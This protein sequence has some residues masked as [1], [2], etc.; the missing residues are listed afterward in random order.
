MKLSEVIW[1][2][3]DLLVGFLWVFAS[4]NVNGNHWVLL[5]VDMVNKAVSVLDSMPKVITK[6][7]CTKHLQ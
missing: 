2:F 7:R 5:V 4:I 6:R 1:I 3:C